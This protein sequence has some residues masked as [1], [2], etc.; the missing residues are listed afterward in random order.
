M[1][2]DWW[3]TPR[4][5]QVLV[6]NE[7]W[8]LPY[9]EQLV[10]RIRDGGDEALLQRAS[11]DVEAGDVLFLLGCINVVGKDILSCNRRNLVVHE[12]DLPHGRGFAPVAWQVLEGAN[13]IPVCLMEATAE[14]DAGPVIY[15]DRFDLEG[16]ELMPE[17]REHQGNK[18]VELC[19]RFLSEQTSPEGTVQE[20]GQASDLHRR[21]HDH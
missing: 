7:S 6:D 1:T 13:H 14:P 16:H 21:Y 11:Q 17:I 15:R 2:L 18:T 10:N 12:S 9:A 4:K 8:V 20:C 19:L 5:I 3:L